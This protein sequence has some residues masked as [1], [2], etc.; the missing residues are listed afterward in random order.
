MFVPQPRSWGQ[1]RARRRILAGL[2]PA[3]VHCHDLV[4]RSALALTW[5]RR[6]L[7]VLV[8]WDEPAIFKALP[9]R[10]ALAHRLLAWWARHSADKIV[11]S[12]LYFRD[13]LREHYG[14]QAEYIP[15]GLYMEAP[16]EAP[17][18]FAAPT[19][20]YMGAMH[21]QWDTDILFEAF[22]IMARHGCKPPIVM[23]GGLDKDAPWPAFC[24]AHQLDNVTF[25]GYLP[26]AEMSRYLRHA[27]VLTFPI[28]PTPLNASR[29]PSKALAYA[30]A[31]R[32]V[33]TSKVGEVAQMLGASATYVEATPQA[34]AQALEQAI[35]APRQSDVDYQIE[36]LSYPRLVEPL[37]RLPD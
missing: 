10:E 8:D 32:P 16:A 4:W 34:M 37:L 6:D 2:A 30:Q 12:S 35:A 24:R 20:V 9:W 17:S 36:R 11:A 3:W 29:C 31:R 14:V 21:V 25:T 19:I 28:R 7:K 26:S 22:A 13:Y 15:Y 23:V 5:Q 1:L 33:I 18:P 27:H